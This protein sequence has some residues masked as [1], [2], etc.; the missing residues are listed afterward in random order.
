M[1]PTNQNWFKYGG[2]ILAGDTEADLGS[3]LMEKYYGDA[4]LV[5]VDAEGNKQWDM[6]FQRTLG[7]VF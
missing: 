2:Y 7:D 6:I 1:V 4:W 5:K 3:D